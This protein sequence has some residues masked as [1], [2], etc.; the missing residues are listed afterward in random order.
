MMNDEGQDSKTLY[1]F[2]RIDFCSTYIT[3]ALLERL[4]NFCPT[5]NRADMF[6]TIDIG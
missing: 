5:P 6:H 4:S 2:A 3:F 1:S